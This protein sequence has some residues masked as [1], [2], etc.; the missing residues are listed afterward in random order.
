MGQLET[1]LPF[2]L[3]GAEVTLLLS[4][5]AFA[6]GLL[7]GLLAA[8]ARLSRFRTARVASQAYI[9]VI[10]GTPLLVQL[11][12]IYFGL[13]EFG[14]LIPAFPAA[15]LALGINYGAYLAEVFRG[16]IL[17]V[18]SGQWEAARSL[19]MRLRPTLRRVIL[20]QAVRF[21][22]PGSGNYAISMLKDT[23]LASTIT[24]DEL[25]RQGQLQVAI[26]F[27]SFQIYLLIA[28]MYLVMSYPLTLIVR[29]LER[30]SARGAA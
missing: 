25:L 13:P 9:D 20:P 3:A 26:Y 15:V 21:A 23:A 16:G 24:V 18:D 10:R 6:L 11:F 14:I 27:D 19:G 8:L 28:L 29:R 12:L 4:V 1:A 5:V 2:L 17:A 22:L 30:R 7:L